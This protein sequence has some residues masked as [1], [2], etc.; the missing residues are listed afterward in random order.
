M[1]FDL[2]T[3][4]GRSQA[5]KNYGDLLLPQPLVVTLVQKALGYIF[6]TD[7]IKQQRKTA[8]ELIKAG[9]KNGVDEMTITLDETAG[10]DI[11]AEV[12]GIPVKAMV[13]KNG[14]VTLKVKYQ[15]A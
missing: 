6:S 8:V 14:K 11:G 1:E 13:G 5:L 7:T 4:Y 9:Q 12:E 3:T 15:N 2:T 10:V